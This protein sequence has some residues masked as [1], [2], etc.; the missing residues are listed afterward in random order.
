MQ[1]RSLSVSLYFDVWT[2][3][4]ADDPDPVTEAE[5]LGG[6]DLFAIGVGPWLFEIS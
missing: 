2:F 4:L 3:D 5:V 1:A 6:H